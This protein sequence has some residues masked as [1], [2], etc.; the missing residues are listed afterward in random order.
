MLVECIELRKKWLFQVRWA[1]SLAVN[2]TSTLS[3]VR[4]RLAH[5]RTQWVPPTDAHA[6]MSLCAKLVRP[7]WLAMYH[8]SHYTTQSCSSAFMTCLC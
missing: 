7:I 3:L 2:I 8:K 1:C 6:W 4:C 5:V